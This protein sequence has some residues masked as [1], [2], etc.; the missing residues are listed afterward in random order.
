MFQY[1]RPSA[2][3]SLKKSMWRP[4]WSR[5]SGCQSKRPWRS[6]TSPR[7]HNTRCHPDHSVR[8]APSI[9]KLG[10][11]H[12]VDDA[13]GRSLSFKNLV[14]VSGDQRYAQPALLQPLLPDAINGSTSVK[15]PRQT[16]FPRNRSRKPCPPPRFMRSKACESGKDCAPTRQTLS[17]QPA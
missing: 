14:E 2:L 8:P 7:L 17:A 15:N 12:D 6:R 4:S 1:Q 16:A 9:I 10:V 3:R 11:R 13:S 5:R